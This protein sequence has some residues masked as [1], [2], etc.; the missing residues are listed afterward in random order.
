MQIEKVLYVSQWVQFGNEERLLMRELFSIPRSSGTIMLDG[1]LTSDGCTQSDLSAVTVEKMQ[2]FLNSTEESFDILLAN[3]L[4]EVYS[5]VKAKHDARFAEQL[6]VQHDEKMANATKI[7]ASIMT[8]IKNLPI[9]AQQLLKQEVD[10]LLG[11]STE[12][13]ETSQE[14]KKG[15]NKRT[16]KSA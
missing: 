4:E 5:L 13:N 14:V 9:E 10:V 11:Q 1:K 15:A 16:A 12:T 7:I 3:T 6:Q 2:R 8:S